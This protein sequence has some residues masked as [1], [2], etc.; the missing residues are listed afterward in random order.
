MIFHL[1]LTHISKSNKVRAKEVQAMMKA[2]RA[3]YQCHNLCL[4]SGC[5]SEYSFLS[6]QNFTP[7]HKLIFFLQKTATELGEKGSSGEN[8]SSMKS[9]GSKMKV[10]QPPFLFQLSDICIMGIGFS[11]CG[12]GGSHG[13]GGGG[14]SSGKSKMFVQ[15]IVL[16]HF[17]TKNLILQFWS[18]SLY[19]VE[20]FRQNQKTDLEFFS[21]ISVV[22]IV[23]LQFGP[24]SIQH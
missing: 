22:D 2:W 23:N 11:G 1:S 13:G 24:G 12:G 5:H 19:L 20:K 18:S 16:A 8:F 10:P 21:I 4:L 7:P 17:H 15:S 14:S 6:D 3:S 9:F